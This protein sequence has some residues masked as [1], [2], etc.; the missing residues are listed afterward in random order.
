VFASGLPYTPVVAGDVNGDGYENDRAFISDPASEPDPVLAA[1][2][3]RVRARAPSGALDCL[4]TQVGRIA[5]PGSC[6]TSWSSSLDI[7]AA[8]LVRGNANTRRLTLTVFASN[9]TA[10]LD[11]L[12]HGSRDLRGWGQYPAPDATLL[13]VRG[14]D[15]GQRAFRYE[16]N[17]NF[18]QPLDLRGRTPFR[19]TL[20]ARLTLGADPRYPPMMA[21]IKEGMGRSR[22]SMREDLSTRVRNIPA[23]LL[24]IAAGDTAA[25]Q[26]TVA[27]RASL[28]ALADSLGPGI[29]AVL[30]SLADVHARPGE[31][32]AIR[33]S[34]L[35]TLTRRATELSGAA[36]QGTR[37]ILTMEQWAR[38]PA[39]LRRPRSVEELSRPPEAQTT[40]QT[41]EP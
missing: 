31:W 30:D 27:Q 15:A 21:A 7:R 12:F 1:A 38:V 41:G 3:G 39:W 20:Q 17:E 40:V 25:L 19:L 29:R 2:L 37:G 34:R 8:M 28:H 16:A 32:S 18:G 22:E 14:F 24:R 13:Q 11:Y 26:L 33:R 35:E 9:V 4:R 5:T 23:L 10:G 6:R 36:L